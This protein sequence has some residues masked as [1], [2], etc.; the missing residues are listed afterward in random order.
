MARHPDQ[1]A[2]DFLGLAALLFVSLR[3]QKRSKLGE[4][5]R[6]ADATGWDEAGASSWNAS[7]ISFM[8]AVSSPKGA[9]ATSMPPLMLLL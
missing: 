7:S 6:V 2:E 5:G 4:Q 9:V 8:A 1:E 3:P